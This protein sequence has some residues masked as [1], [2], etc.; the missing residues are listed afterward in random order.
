MFYVSKFTWTTEENC[1]EIAIYIHRY[2]K[3]IYKYTA[4]R[5]R[6]YPVY[7]GSTAKK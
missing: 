3:S 7:F 1:T 4:M 6:V 2:A 5:E